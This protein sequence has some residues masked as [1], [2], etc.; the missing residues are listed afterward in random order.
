MLAI[1]NLIITLPKETWVVSGNCHL[2]LI[3]FHHL[4]KSFWCV[5]LGERRIVNA[6]VIRHCWKSPKWYPSACVYLA[7]RVVLLVWK[8]PH[9]NPSVIGQDL[10][11]SPSGLRSSKH[12][13]FSP[14]IMRVSMKEP[15]THTTIWKIHT[16]I[17]KLSPYFTLLI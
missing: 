15:H 6:F 17:W 16:T 11:A 1:C 10:L 7:T 4:A 9:M 12:L 5:L 13:K 2:N 8:L 14:R 3:L